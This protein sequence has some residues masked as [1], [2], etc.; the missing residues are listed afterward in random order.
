M[1]KLA[2]QVIFVLRLM[3]FFS[4]QRKIFELPRPIGMKLWHVIGRW[5]NFKI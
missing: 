2:E 3:F 5:R 1:W 4:F